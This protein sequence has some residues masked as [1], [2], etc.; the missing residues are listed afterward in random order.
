MF[1]LVWFLNNLSLFKLKL[2]VNVWLVWFR[3]IF[4]GLMSDAQFQPGSFRLNWSEFWAWPSSAPACLK[5]FSKFSQNFL[6]IFPKFSQ[7]F[8][9]I[10]LKLLKFFKIFLKIFLNIFL[11][12]IS[13]FFSQFFSKFFQNF[14]KI[15]S[16]LFKI[17]KKCW[18]TQNFLQNFRFQRSLK[19]PSQLL[20]GSTDFQYQYI[21]I[22]N[23][24]ARTFWY[25]WYLWQKNFGAAKKLNYFPQNVCCF[26]DVPVFFVH[27]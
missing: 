20:N 10:F 9:K 5:I 7:N 3:L 25:I 2:K 18:F 19:K 21:K 6:K 17:F 26:S 16:I 13:K 23:M 22:K 1:G 15:A 24:K 14:P 8:L 4:L 12:F 27:F 11:K